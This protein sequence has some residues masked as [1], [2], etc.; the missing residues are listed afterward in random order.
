MASVS[1]TPWCGSVVTVTANTVYSLK[2]LIAAA[3][4]PPA[5]LLNP[6]GV[7]RACYISIQADI[8]GG[9]AK[10]YLGSKSTMT[11]TDCG[12]AM[13]ATQVWNP[14]SLG[15]NLYILDNIFLMS[16]TG[17]AQWNITFITR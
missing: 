4:S 11:T 12:V 2:T 1:T 14:P 13:F 7:L 9:A 16:D 10:Y 17:N 3:G 5:S 6:S 15:G 8:A